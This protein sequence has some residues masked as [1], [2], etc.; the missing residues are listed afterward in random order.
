MPIIE[1]KTV[2]SYQDFINTIDRYK[3]RHRLVIKLRK[4]LHK[5]RTKGKRK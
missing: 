3:Q 4:P 1:Y 5:R 2:A